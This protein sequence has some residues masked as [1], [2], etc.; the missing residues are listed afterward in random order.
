MGAACASCETAGRRWPRRAAARR[1]TRRPAGA[2]AALFQVHRHEHA[3]LYLWRAR[4]HPA[5]VRATAGRGR[6]SV[7]SVDAHCHWSLRPGVRAASLGPDCDAV[8]AAQAARDRKSRDVPDP[9]GASGGIV[10][11]ARRQ[12]LCGR[13]APEAIQR[14]GIRRFAQPTG[15]L[16][17]RAKTCYPNMGPNGG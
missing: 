6:A 2:G 11:P 7:A 9:K 4:T 16:A 14:L 1:R 5:G 8:D 15:R 12:A 10:S 3:R 13:F 17:G